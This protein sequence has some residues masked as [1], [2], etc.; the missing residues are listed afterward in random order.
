M[1]FVGDTTI[2]GTL[3]TYRFWLTQTNVNRWIAEEKMSNKA[4]DVTFIYGNSRIVYNAGAW[5]HGSPYHSP[6]YDSPVGAGCDYDMGFPPDE[7]LLGE[8]DINLFR[9]GNGGGD[10]T[11]Q[12]EIHGYWFGSQFGL[13][14]LYSRPIFV[15]VNGQRRETT[16]YD[17]QQ[18]N[19]DFVRQWF[20][21]DSD[22][23]LHKIQI[24]FEFGD[25]AYG[26]SE[27]GF[28]GVGADLNRYTTTGGAFK[29]ARYRQTWPLRSASPFEQ[30]DYTN[31]F[32]LVNA[33][34]TPSPIGS[35]AYTATLANTVDVEEWFKVDVTEHLFN[36]NDSYSY[37][38]GQ[39]AFS[40]KPEREGWKLLLWDID[41]AFG[42]DPND[43]NL[44]SIGGAEHGPRNDH[45]SFRRIYFQAL[46]EAANGFLTAARSNPILEARYNGM[47]AAGAGVGSPAGIE[48]FIVAKRNVVLNQIAA[49]QST[50]A[51]TSNG[52]ADFTT[53][54]NL[55]T[56]T[57]TAPLEVRTILINGIAYPISWPSLN[58]WVVRLPLSTGTN[59]LQITG[60][61]PKG[62]PVAG[63]TG[64]IRVTYTGAEESPQDKVVINEI[65]YNPVFGSASYVEI[66]NS[67]VSNAFDMS[68]WRLDGV[69]YTFVP[70]TIIEPGMY[71]ILAQDK[72]AFASAY[73]SSIPVLGE[74][75]GSLAGSGE[76]LTLVKPGT[77]QALDQIIDQV[78]YDNALP[79]PSAADGTGASLQLIDPKQDNNRV[80]NW[81]A[82]PTNTPQIGAQWQYV[83]ASGNASSTVLYMY[84]QSAGD[85]YIDDVKIVPGNTPEV[86]VNSVQNGDFETAFPGPWTVSANL[87]R[88]VISTS[89]KHSG[90]SSLHLISSAAGTT[91]ASSI[92]QSLTPALTTGQPYTLSF[93]YLQNTN[94]GPLTLR[95]SGSGI[96]VTTNINLPGINTIARFTP[97]RANTITSNLLAYPTLWLNEVLPN[98]FFLGT[99]GIVDGFGD[100]DPWVE[101]YN[102]GTN[103]LSL[104][105]YF[106]SDNYTNIG[107]W[108]F[109]GNA[110]IAA[111]QFMTVWLDGEPGESTSTELHT[112]F[113]IAPDIGSVVLSRGTNLASIVDYLNFNIPTPGRSYGS[114]PD[115][116]V[117]HR[118]VFGTVTPGATNNPGF[119]PVDIRINEWMA[120]NATSLADPADGK[121]EDWIELYNPNTNSVDL[122]GFF[123][124]DTLTNT[125]DSAIP[126]G[127]LIPAGGYLLVWADGTPSQNSP[128][129]QDIHVK[130][131]LSKSGEAIGLFA[132]DGRLVDGV[133]FGAQ[134]TDVSRGRFPDG[135]T[136]FFSFTN[137]TPRAA[138]FVPDVNTPPTISPIGDRVIDEGTRLS[139]TIVA[140]DA[141]LPKQN[142]TYSFVGFPPSGSS[143]NPGTGAF[144]W[145][146]SEPQGPGVFQITFQVSDDGSPPASSTQTITVTVNEANNAPV[147]ASILSTTLNEGANLTFTNRATDSDSPAQTITWSLQNAPAG[148]N[149]DPASGIFTWTPAEN[150]GPGTYTIT[151]VAT[152]NGVPPRSGSRS[153]TVTVNELNSTPS[154]AFQGNWTVQPE[155]L[156]SFT[157]TTSDPDLPA[158]MLTFSL[159]PGAPAGASIDPATGAFTRTPSA[160][161][162]GTNL[163]TLRVSDNATPPA[164]AS[165]ILRVIVLP[166]LTAD[167]RCG[168]I[169]STS[170]A[171]LFRAEPTVSNTRPT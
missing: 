34:L 153:F 147:V 152:D 160:S 164:S 156:V 13:P 6:G 57:G 72:I 32:A 97:G 77:T 143:L 40:Y 112:S 38:G 165:Q 33:V 71:F 127:T 106:L 105:N 20:P 136:S 137:P 16:Y 37:G 49:N 2:P 155:N 130:F 59:V 5:F 125:T 28:A 93:W 15:F 98:N 162:S 123:M 17:A 171:M 133:T 99:N 14:F 139:F 124:S 67:S 135:T 114:Y 89:I 11:S 18:P 43:A 39:N 8:T 68:N 52:G 73:G 111:K 58:T 82:V 80:S 36:N 132:P 149:I 35:D 54:R 12:A 126:A 157:A 44:F 61:N 96:L 100:R 142:L 70:G 76:T 159:D 118:R 115:G 94:G 154:I 84:M 86:G 91:Q 22:G 83:V 101:I 145:V 3:P 117:S 90:N 64:T 134:T 85:V 1:L 150:Q 167:R 23:E 161:F 65:M 10:G 144:S 88:S 103:S 21:D 109:P 148:A 69:G 29:Q 122:T 95:L 7:P 170:T 46:I 119:P 60:I 75:P 41:F 62:L 168:V 121:F 79:W 74:F 45:P 24:G 55:I 50:F 138:N 25:L 129:N 81:S 110:S 27:P 19:G 78:S 9:P 56:I 169:P 47:V 108:A 66:F 151:V 63:V 131:S 166:V 102:G 158:Q 128:T 26:V 120:D 48:N 140:T 31:L 53:N 146:P 163:M 141:N 51:I 42:G 116:A 92:W 30:N 4:K 107:Q 113:R 87:S 104:S